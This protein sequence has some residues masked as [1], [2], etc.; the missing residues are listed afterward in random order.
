[1]VEGILR[2]ADALQLDVVAEGIETAGQRDLL[3][4]M[5][6]R[7]GQGYYFSRP[8]PAAQPTLVSHT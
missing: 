4:E 2:L 1:M 7:Y 8:S 3:R 6:C 5:G